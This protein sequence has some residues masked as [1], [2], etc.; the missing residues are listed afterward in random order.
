MTHDNHPPAVPEGQGKSFTND[1]L[2]AVAAKNPPPVEWFDGEE[3]PTPAIE[4]GEE[5]SEAEAV[6]GRG[7]FKLVSSLLTEAN[8]NEVEAICLR[9]KVDQLEGEVERLTSENADLRSRLSEIADGLRSVSA[10]LE[11]LRG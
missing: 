6:M 8:D 1:E 10:N 5:E 2:L 3:S 4:R 9:E 7:N 11:H